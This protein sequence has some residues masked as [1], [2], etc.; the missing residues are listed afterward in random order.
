MKDAKLKVLVNSSTGFIG[1]HLIRKLLN[2]GH[3]VFI[4]DNLSTGK[5]EHM[6]I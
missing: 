5:L 1:S 4:L 2:D 3:N 6:M